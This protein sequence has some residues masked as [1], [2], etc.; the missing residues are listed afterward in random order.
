M[1]VE[2][3]EGAGLCEGR[4]FV[5]DVKGVVIEPDVGLD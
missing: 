1:D 3:V 4:S 2:A 5:A